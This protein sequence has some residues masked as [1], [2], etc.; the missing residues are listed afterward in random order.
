MLLHISVHLAYIGQSGRSIAIRHKEHVRYTRTNNP[1][2][3]YAL[4]ILNNKY[5]FETAE[6]TL[7]LLKPCHKDPRMNCWE[8]FY[9]QLFH[10]HG[11]LINEQR[12]NDI[13]PLYEIADTSRIP[14]HAPQ[15][16]QKLHDTQ[17]TPQLGK[18]DKSICL[19]SI[20]IPKVRIFNFSECRKACCHNTE[21]L[22]TMYFTD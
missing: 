14:I 20:C 6:E 17:Y 19:Y 5:D 1:T 7:K 3:A 18:S 21:K 2:Y 11:T 13:N 4:H 9:M 12:L 10:Q 15:I 16:S 22:K 8:T